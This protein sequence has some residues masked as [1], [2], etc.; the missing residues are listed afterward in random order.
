MDLSTVLPV[1]R[2]NSKF[3]VPV[4]AY[5]PLLPTGWPAEHGA[6]HMSTKALL[7]CCLR[8]TCRAVKLSPLHAA[9]KLLPAPPLDDL[10]RPGRRLLHVKDHDCITPA[11]AADAA[12]KVEQQ[13]IR[14]AFGAVQ[15]M[16]IL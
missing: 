5:T 7:R 15:W 11:G 14:T 9:S 4:K 2:S 6:R 1:D 3:P 12:D 13:H 10:D 8:L 16:G